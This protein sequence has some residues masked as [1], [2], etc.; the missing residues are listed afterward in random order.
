MKNV[1]FS[2]G[3]STHTED[4]FVR[5]LLRNGVTAVADVRSAPY[6]KQNPQFNRE[7]L[8]LMLDSNDIR[9]LFL[10]NELGGRSADPTCYVNGRVSYERVAQTK[11]FETGLTRLI[12][13]SDLYTIAIMCSEKE[14]LNCHR[15]LLIARQLVARG[16]DVHHILA[17]GRVENHDDTMERLA[18]ML[19]LRNVEM[20]RSHQEMISHAY[21]KQ[22]SRIA[23]EISGDP[24]VSL[25]RNRDGNKQWKSSP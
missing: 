9:Y 18:G 22:A 12:E 19:D 16:S 13:E 11:G 15:S 23:Y 24:H 6:S 21:S 25:N 1:F 10:G 5:L 3:H 4:E 17:D 14:P 20:F 8:D 2:I 7:I